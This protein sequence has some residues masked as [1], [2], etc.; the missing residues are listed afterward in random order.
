METLPKRTSSP[1]PTSSS[2]E[3]GFISP[4]GDSSFGAEKAE[5]LLPSFFSLPMD[6][7][8]PSVLF[9]PLKH[10]VVGMFFLVLVS[11]CSAGTILGHSE[12]EW[13][14]AL[15]SGRSLPFPAGSRLS[16]LTRLGPGTLLFMAMQAED[17]QDQD[18]ARDL[19]SAAV[20]HE[21]GL[22]ASLAA[23]RYL[24]LLR[25]QSDGPG[26]LAFATSEGGQEPFPLDQGKRRGRSPGHDRPTR[27]GP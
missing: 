12:A 6:S 7:E 14:D 21:T 18:S 19:L 24:R 5:A 15:A 22:Y 23:E 11:A 8:Y 17:R 26:L 25:T 1:T 9:R 16:E 10:M 3:P 2:P 27:P 4:H 20:A 13:L